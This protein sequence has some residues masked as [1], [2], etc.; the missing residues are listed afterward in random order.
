MYLNK[1]FFFRELINYVCK[2]FSKSINLKEILL[3]HLSVKLSRIMHSC[4]HCHPYSNLVFFF[5]YYFT[6]EDSE[7]RNETVPFL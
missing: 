3:N 6:L 1:Y 4:I 7:K 5:F 2:K